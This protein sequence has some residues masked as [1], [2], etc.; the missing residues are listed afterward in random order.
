MTDKPNPDDQR[1]IWNGP[2][3]RVW[4]EQQEL[5]DH[6]LQP[7]E[8]RLVDVI[9]PESG[10]VLDVGCGTGSTTLAI[11]RRLGTANVTGVDIS[12]P[13]LGLAK[14][15]GQRTPH[16][17]TFILADAQTYAFEPAAFDAILSRFGVMFFEDPT[18][19]FSNLHRAAKK[20]A[21]LRFIAWRTAAE[22]PFMTTAERTAGPL[23]AALPPRRPDGPGQFAFGDRTR[24]EDILR[25]SGWS[26]IDIA[27]IDASCTMPESKLLDYVT[28]VG[29]VGR[30]LSDLDEAARAPVVAALRAAFEPFVHGTEVRFDGACWLV[31]ARA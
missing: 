29:P 25:S 28:K 10:R 7:F 21:A 4:V 24:V 1:A 20:G 11:A 22:N 19:A 6:V 13:M 15:R 8:S 12:E 14:T 3:G 2:G 26:S 27:P 31:Q 16:P 18:R 30:A 9:T 17:P 23:L 5:L